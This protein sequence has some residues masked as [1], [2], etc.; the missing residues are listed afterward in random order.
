MN[1]LELFVLLHEQPETEIDWSIY[2]NYEKLLG[3]SGITPNENLRVLWDSLVMKL[4]VPLTFKACEPKIEPLYRV[5]VHG[6]SSR[7]DHIFESH[8]VVLSKIE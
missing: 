5:Q 4:T 3:M 1:E 7:F 2:T 8:S 6:D